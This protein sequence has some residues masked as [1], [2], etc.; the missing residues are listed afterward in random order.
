MANQTRN[1]ASAG[2][3]FTG[4][5]TVAWSDPSNIAT[6]DGNRVTASIAGSV[7]SRPLRLTVGIGDE[8]AVP[9]GSSLCGFSGHTYAALNPDALETNTGVLVVGN[10]AQGSMT[11][12]E[13][14]QIANAAWGGPAIPP[15]A[16]P[17]LAQV[18]GSQFGFTVQIGVSAIGTGGTYGIDAADITVHFVEPA[19]LLSPADAAT[20]IDGSAGVLLEWEEEPD[21]AELMIANYVAISTTN[22]PPPE[23]W[24]APFD[25]AAH[26]FLTDP[27]GP[28]TYYWQ[29]IRRNVG[30]ISFVESE[31][32]SFTVS[33]PVPDQN[34]LLSPADE[35][36]NVSL[37]P[38]L[39]WEEN[40]NDVMWHNVYLD[41][42][43]PPTTVVGNKLNAATTA[44][45]VGPLTPDTAYYWRVDA[46]GEGGTVPSEVWL[47]TT[48]EE[49]EPG[50]D[51]PP[52]RQSSRTNPRFRGSVGVR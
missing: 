50:D 2:T 27:L 5:G 36:T 35:A 18:N 9:A 49:P 39:M 4:G 12:T 25:G 40:S 28:G 17:S 32:R 47:F 34:V 37:S 10:T 11:I 42:S 52:K 38:T 21:A 22:P 16:M 44:L 48:I 30:D 23:S 29:V 45:P 14:Y 41:T 19:P 51:L 20:G 1:I 43:N 15:P 7:T 46:V 3:L 8:F 24:S 6:L 13:P 33:A 26:E 31:V